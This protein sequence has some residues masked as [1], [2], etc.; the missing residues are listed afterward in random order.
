MPDFEFSVFR[1]VNIGGSEGLERAGDL[2]VRDDNGNQDT[3]FNDI[4]SAGSGETNGD[5]EIIASDFGE[6]AVGDTIRTRG[7]FRFTNNDTGET[8]DFIEIFSETAGNPIEQLFIFTSTAP[9]W[10]FDSTSRSL[11]LLNADG[12][13]PYS[14]IVCFCEGTLI[15]TS[16]RGEVAV[17]LLEVGGTV[18]TQDGSAREISWIGQQEISAVELMVNPKL[19]PICIKAGS[20]GAG[21]PT[22]DLSVS[23][24]HR[25]LVNSKIVHRIFGVDEVLVPANKLVGLEGI[26]VAETSGDVRYFHIMLDEHQVIFANGALSESLFFG[27]EALKSMSDESLAE[28]SAIFPKLLSSDCGAM[29]ACHIPERGKEVKSLI[30]RHAKNGKPLVAIH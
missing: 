4:E 17:E 20:L 23:P 10:L 5:Q 18:V 26:Q 28:L 13:I 19:R 11:T 21:L 6:L 7:I 30:A 8:Y 22:Q 16:D 12:T 2:T 3:V 25:M 9:D 1:I 24:Q 29:P 14:S 15:K 27:P